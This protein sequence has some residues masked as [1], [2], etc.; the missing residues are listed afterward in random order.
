MIQTVPWRARRLHICH[1]HRRQGKVAESGNLCDASYDRWE[2]W[3]L[4]RRKAT[5]AAGMKMG[6]PLSQRK[7]VCR[8]GTLYTGHLV[9]CGQLCPP[10]SRIGRFSQSVNIPTWETGAKR[11]KDFETYIVTEESKF[12]N[13]NF[14]LSALLWLWRRWWC[15]AISSRVRVLPS[16]LEAS[17]DAKC[18]VFMPI[19]SPISISWRVGAAGKLVMCWTLRSCKQLVTSKGDL[20]LT[21]EIVWLTPNWSRSR[22][23][24]FGWALNVRTRTVMIL[25]NWHGQL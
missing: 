2:Q 15:S 7:Y 10:R 23:V 24:A 1:I 14:G 8:Q 16:L 22:V 25:F 17:N 9:R 18:E 3:T 11:E 13:R 6:N 5:L 12:P 21:N 20:A 4:G 19:L